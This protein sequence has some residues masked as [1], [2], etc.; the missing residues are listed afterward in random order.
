MTLDDV[1]VGDKVLLDWYDSLS[2]VEVVRLTNTQIVIRAK[3]GNEY[4]FYKKNGEIAH[5]GYDD[6]WRGKPEIS[7]RT[8]ATDKRF[9]AQQKEQ[10]RRLMIGRIRDIAFDKLSTEQLERIWGIINE[11]TE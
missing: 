1:K 4:R 9:A 10:K 8:E 5:G 2:Y 11:V 6:I 7:V 3:N